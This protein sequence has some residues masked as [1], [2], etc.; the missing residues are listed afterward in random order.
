MKYRVQVTVK[1]IVQ[2]EERDFDDQADDPVDEYSYDVDA[3]NPEAASEAALDIFHST[4]P[5][6]C[7]EHFDIDTAVTP[8]S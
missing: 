6:A 2:W 5:I 1:P 3:A 7:L 4:V 8:V